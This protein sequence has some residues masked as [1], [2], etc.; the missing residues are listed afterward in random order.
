MGQEESPDA[1]GPDAPTVPEEGRHG[2]AR[3]SPMLGI[4]GLVATATGTVGALVAAVLL[5][6]RV[7]AAMGLF[8]ADG[9]YRDVLPASWFA[10]LD[11]FRVPI[12][13]FAVFGAAGWLTS[14]VAVVAGRGRRYGVAALILG[15]ALFAIRDMVLAPTYPPMHVKVVYVDQ[16][17][18]PPDKP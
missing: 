5:R 4:I 13:V 10:E 15:L 3:K 2:E 14:I 7:D 8:G 16:C 17:Q 6:M 12:V 11:V 9:Y 18:Q 1:D